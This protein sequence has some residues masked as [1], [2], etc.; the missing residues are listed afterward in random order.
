MEINTRT[1]GQWA[2]F[3]SFAVILYYCFRIMEPFLMP[4]FL[5]LILSTLLT[6]LYESIARRL[7]NRTSLS[8][9]LVCLGL[10]LAIILPVLLL[11]VSLAREATNVYTSLQDPEMSSKVQLWLN[12]NSNPAIAKI[13]TWLPKS[14]R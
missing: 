7:H 12:P 4:I 14:M 13:Q 3:G 2:L 5:A 1:L 11:S 6:P 9:L 10:T 8:A